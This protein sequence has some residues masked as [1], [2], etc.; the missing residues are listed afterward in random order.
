MK[1]FDLYFPIDAN[2]L[3]IYG[4]QT[5]DSGSYRCTAQNRFGEAFH[6]EQINIEGNA[7]IN[8]VE[9]NKFYLLNCFYFLFE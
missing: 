6:Q 7:F 1:S 9:F 5:D 2:T 3:T 4:V 8:F